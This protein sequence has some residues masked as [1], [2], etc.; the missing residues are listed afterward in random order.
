MNYN[1]NIRWFRHDDGT[2]LGELIQFRVMIQVSY[3]AEKYKMIHNNNIYIYIGLSIYNVMRS[4]ST[5][6]F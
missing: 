3:S 4:V 6:F 5:K 2:L 1:K